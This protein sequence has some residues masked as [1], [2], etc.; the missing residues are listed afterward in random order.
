MRLT[1]QG[2]EPPS[3]PSPWQLSRL[4]H[5][6]G[7]PSRPDTVK[8]GRGHAVRTADRQGDARVQARCINRIIRMPSATSAVVFYEKPMVLGERTLA[9]F[10]LEVWRQVNGKWVL[11]RETVEHL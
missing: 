10:V 8:R 4:C 6:A 5:G 9:A 3:L 11:I 1:L 7:R 2:A